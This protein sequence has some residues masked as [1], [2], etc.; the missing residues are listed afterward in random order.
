MIDKNC[1]WC[2]KW[3]MNQNQ[4]PTKNGKMIKKV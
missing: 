4:K 1:G 3:N 2:G